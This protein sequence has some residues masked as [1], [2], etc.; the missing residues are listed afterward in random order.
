[1]AMSQR[2][3][4]YLLGPLKLELNNTPI[5]VDRRKVLALMAYLTINREQ[6]TREYL[7]AMLWPEYD[8]EKAF[9]NLRHTLWETQQ[10]IGEGWIIA[11]RDKVGINTDHAEE[12]NIWLDVNH[13][14]SLINDSHAQTDISL[15][16]SLLVDSAELYRNHFLTG[17]S[18]KDA[19]NF[20]EWAFAKSEELRHQLSHIL[21]VLS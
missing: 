15:R 8:Q 1:V 16:T 12:R 13:F 20:N 9:T 2:L 5:A 17:F 4:L 11:S 21:N 14:E 6:H 10:A 3:A 7:S 18:L 19:P